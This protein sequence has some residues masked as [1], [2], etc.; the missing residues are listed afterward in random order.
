MQPTP[1]ARRVLSRELLDVL[2]R[3][4]LIAVL[5]VSC[6]RIF[7]PFRNLMVWAMIL[8]IT[9]YPLQVRLRG[10]FILLISFG[11]IL[12]PTYMLGV[13]V[14]DSVEHAMAVVRSGSFRIPPPAESVAS[15]PLGGQRVFD[16]WQQVST[17]LAGLAHKFAPQLKEAARALLGTLTGFGAGLLIFF[18]ALN[19]DHSDAARI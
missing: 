8:A 12:A 10:R 11:V 7:V 1:I 6:F 3:A 17:D 15:R 4:G 5:A 18:V 19:C 13:A 2:I 16:F 9:L 14:A